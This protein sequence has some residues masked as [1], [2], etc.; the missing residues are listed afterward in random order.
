M[1]K[2]LSSRW[3]LLNFLLSVPDT[4]ISV[5]DLYTY[6]WASGNEETSLAQVAH[7]C[8]CLSREKGWWDDRWSTLSNRAKR[9]GENAVAMETVCSG[10]SSCSLRD[11]K[12]LVWSSFVQICEKKT[13]KKN[14]MR[15]V[16]KKSKN[17]TV[18]DSNIEFQISIDI[19]FNYYSTEKFQGFLTFLYF[20]Y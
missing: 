2:I 6:F 20:Y 9:S 19:L 1:I 8:S 7:S 16:D 11:S 18:N 12:T 5:W 3:S 17:A 15:I 13:K 4:G 10:I 14:L